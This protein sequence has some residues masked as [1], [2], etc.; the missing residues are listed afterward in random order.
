MHQQYIDSAKNITSASTLLI[1][2]SVDIL[3]NHISKGIIMKTHKNPHQLAKALLRTHHA[4]GTAKHLNMSNNI[5]SVSSYNKKVSIAEKIIKDTSFFLH[6][7]YEELTENLAQNYLDNMKNLVVQTTINNFKKVFNNE[8]GFNLKPVTSNVMKSKKLA[9]YYPHEVNIVMEHQSPRN[10]ISTKTCYIS[11]LRAHELA[12]IIPA[13]YEPASL[14]RE[15]RE[16]LFTGMDDIE[17]YSVTGK[18]GLTRNVAFTTENSQELEKLRLIESQL[19]KDRKI[20][21]LQHYE[22][23]YGQAWSQSF[24]AAS[25]KYL[26]W[27]GGGHSLRYSY[28]QNRFDTLLAQQLNYDDCLLILS[29]ELGHFRK[30]IIKHHYL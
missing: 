17:L 21:Y 10:A 29:Q 5:H 27:S 11:G 2:H 12:T 23:G 14:H 13:E 9:Y 24:S 28:V 26:G 20:I 6:V 4:I 18:G 15:W 8:F 30:N 25:K 3:I 1:T 19:V 16:D 22:I 7:S